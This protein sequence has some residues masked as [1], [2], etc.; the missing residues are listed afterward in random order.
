MPK[1]IKHLQ[2]LNKVNKHTYKKK[3][4]YI[5][6]FVAN[7]LNMNNYSLGIVTSC[8]VQVWHD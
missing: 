2:Y 5:I 7:Y 3:K 1:A 4:L 8:R 6:S